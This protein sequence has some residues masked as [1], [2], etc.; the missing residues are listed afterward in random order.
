MATLSRKEM[1]QVLRQG[2][3][4]LHDGKIIGNI[5]ALPTEADLAGT[6]TEAI[7][8]AE[9][10]IDNDIKRLLA[11]KQKIAKAKEEAAKSAK[12]GGGEAEEKQEKPKNLEEASQQANAPNPPAETDLNEEG[13]NKT[14]PSSSPQPKAGD[15]KDEK[16]K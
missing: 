15:K 13:G 1:E 8:V 10:N 3:T 12:S 7:K 9:E 14:S 6:D 4:I 16:A 11:E 2:G 5:N